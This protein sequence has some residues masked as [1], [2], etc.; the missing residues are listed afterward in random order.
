MEWCKESVHLFEA[1]EQ[2]LTAFHRAQTPLQEGMRPR[3][4]EWVAV[5]KQR[6]ICYGSLVKAH[7]VYWKHVQMHGCRV[8]AGAGE[9]EAG[10]SRAA[11]AAAA[12]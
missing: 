2:A 1:Y 6:D 3:G 12:P 4:P 7:G 10:I 11:K 9:P 8:P 5:G